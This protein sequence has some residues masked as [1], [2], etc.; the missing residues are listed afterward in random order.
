MVNMKDLANRIKGLEKR[1]NRCLLC[2]SCAAN[3]P[4]GVNLPGKSGLR[5]AFFT[6]CI[7]DKRF[8]GIGNDLVEQLIP[9]KRRLFLK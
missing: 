2:G 1:L 8:P 5:V 9:G 6:G 4:S 3:C 7:I